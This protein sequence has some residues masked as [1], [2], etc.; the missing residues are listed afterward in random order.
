MR[1]MTSSP[2]LSPDSA[3]HAHRI[4][5]AEEA[6]ST[7]LRDDEILLIQRCSCE[8]TIVPDV[9]SVCVLLV[10]GGAWPELA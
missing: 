1:P 9:P 2:S 6:A 5:R 4:W 10:L 7:L 8:T 3:R